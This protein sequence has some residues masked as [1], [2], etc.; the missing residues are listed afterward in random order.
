MI[1]R[2]LVLGLLLALLASCVPIP[3]RVVRGS[4]DTVTVEVNATDFD[5]VSAG[6]AFEVD[7]TQGDD[8]QVLVT[9]DQ[10]LEE[11]LRV[12]KQGSRL[13]IQLDPAYNYVNSTLRAEITMPTL[14]GLE[15][16]GACQG[17]IDGFDATDRFD[18]EISGASTLRG[19]ITT[20]DV[21][22][23]V[24]GASRAE[25]EGSGQDLRLEASGASHV[26]MGDFT[27]RNADVE[28]S[29]ASSAVVNVSGRLD[30]EATGASS[31][32]YRGDPELGNIQASGAGSVRPD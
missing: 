10:N 5:E 24:S 16:S 31:V 27:V 9:V 1:R 23:N 7:I 20:G 28:V 8:Y 13:N 22:M 21:T 30:A 4:G 25:L 17:S 14:V 6:Y 2:I 18:V 11:Y 32:R 15:L 12:G 3:T 29:G 19:D 26:T